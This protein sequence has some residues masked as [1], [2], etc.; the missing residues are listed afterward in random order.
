M[1]KTLEWRCPLFELS[2]D[3][4]LSYSAGSG[5]RD[6]FGYRVVK[7]VDG[8][9][10]AIARYAPALIGQILKAPPL[11]VQA[12]PATLSLGPIGP[13]VDTYLHAPTASRALSL[14]S[15]TDRCA[16]MCTTPLHAARIVALHQ[17]LME[18]F[19]KR[20]ILAIGGYPLPISLERALQQWCSNQSIE[21]NIIQFYGQ[22]EID[23]ACLFSLKRDTAGEPIYHPRDGVTLSRLDDAQIEIRVNEH[24]YQFEDSITEV[25]G[26]FRINNSDR[27]SARTLQE[28][29]K[30]SSS[31]WSRRTGFVRHSESG[32]WIQVRENA[33][34]KA[35]NELDFYEYARQF[36]MDW[37]QKPDWR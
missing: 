31:D 28:L 16:L 15:A 11:V 18:Q 22:A 1:L 3:A 35:P 27:W 13:K 7:P 6:P 10:S 36:K 33:S 24:V 8:L 29:N 12:Y 20:L 32:T 17:S 14:A 34:P 26:G 2:P 30:W 37:W 19:P 23:A 4:I 25:D 5:S 9:F 21:L